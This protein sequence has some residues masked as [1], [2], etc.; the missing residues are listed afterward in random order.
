LA[1]VN[2]A[3]IGA[4]AAGASAQELPPNRGSVEAHD[5]E[6]I[7]SMQLASDSECVGDYDLL[8]RLGEGAFGKV[9]KA[10][11][12]RSDEL[13]AV[14]QIKLGARSW[15]E[16]LRST[17]LQA[18]RA[19][20]HPFIVRLRELIRSQQDGSLYYIFEFVDSDLCKLI[21]QHPGGMDEL[22]AAFLARQVFAALAHVHQHSFFHRDI[23]P[24]N[25]LLDL[26]TETVRLADFGEAR[27]L[28]ARPPFTDYVGT[29][30]YR[31]PEF[32]VR[33]RLTHHLSTFGLQGLSLQSSCWVRL[34]F[35]EPR[36]SINST[37]FFPWWVTLRH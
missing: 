24:E 28:R 7:I 12:R 2:L 25:V 35:V 29:R 22:R 3:H 17:E 4:H 15:D 21:A 19:L 20:R 11:H 30:W 5:R 6:S 23:K 33:T 13:A 8:H 10:K 18:L 16:A 14:K 31:A 9:Y 26:A 36:A 1:Q 32:L 37:R 34:F 27:S